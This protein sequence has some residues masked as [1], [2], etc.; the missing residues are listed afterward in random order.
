MRHEEDADKMANSY[1]CFDVALSILI[2]IQKALL[3]LLIFA[4]IDMFLGSFIDIEFGTL[5]VDS[6]EDGYHNID[7]DQ[8]IRISS[9]ALFVS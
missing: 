8:V 1:T 7:Q 5:Y 4:Q 6:I 3:V 9:D 2:R